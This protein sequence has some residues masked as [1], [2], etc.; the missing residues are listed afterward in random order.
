MNKHI[1][2]YINNINLENITWLNLN[3]SELKEFLE[4]N[5]FDKEKWE[6]VLDK[7]KDTIY[8]VLLGMNYLNI[9]S[10][11]NNKSSNFFLGVVNN[12][13]GKKTI[14]SAI[15]YLEEYYMFTNQNIPLTYISTIEVNSYFRNKGIYKKS[16]KALLNFLNY[17]QHIL[18]S[19]QSEMGKK[20]KVFEIFKETA[21]NNGF[22]NQIL[23]DNYS[24]NTKEFQDIICSKTKVLKK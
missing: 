11:I 9:Y 14:I 18:I 1:N 8:P 12:N 16:C 13:I 22:Q 17:D 5:Y 19:K 4:E 15:I 10:H 2:D 6:Y 20:C 21:L 7:S 3:S 24:I 23:E